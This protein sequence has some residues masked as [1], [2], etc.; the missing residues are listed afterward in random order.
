L[1][2][3]VAALIPFFP[4]A[5]LV[6]LDVAAAGRCHHYL[7]WFPRL[8]SSIGKQMHTALGNCCLHCLIHQPF[9]QD[10]TALMNQLSHQLLKN[11]NPSALFHFSMDKQG[12]KHSSNSTSSQVVALGPLAVLLVMP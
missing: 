2:L 8:Y 11:V 5:V 12:N 3:G 4:L 9:L 1:T 6:L 10:V 7:N